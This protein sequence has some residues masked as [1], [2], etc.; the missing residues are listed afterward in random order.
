MQSWGERLKY[1]AAGHCVRSVPTS[2][3][4]LPAIPARLAFTTSEALPHDGFRLRARH[5]VHC[6]IFPECH[7]PSA[8]SSSIPA[9]RPEGLRSRE[10]TVHS[11]HSVQYGTGV[12]YRLGGD[13]IHASDF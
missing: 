6:T 4:I 9:V 1:L 5:R 11:V 12:V 8:S 7:Q 3:S 13:L 2:L 10:Y